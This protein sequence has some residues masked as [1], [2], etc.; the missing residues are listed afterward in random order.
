MK[1]EKGRG[2]RNNKPMGGVCDPAASL[3]QFSLRETLYKM[4]R[5]GR[6]RKRKLAKNSKIIVCFSH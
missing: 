3:I 1:K 6:R 4:G 5:G 2:R